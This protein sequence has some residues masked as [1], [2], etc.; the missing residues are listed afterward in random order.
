MA[1]IKLRRDTAANWSSANP[2]LA[3]GEPGYDTTNNKLKVGDGTTAWNSLDYLT[4]ESG[5]GTGEWSFNGDT[6]YNNE[7]NGLYI[8]PS[9]G[10]NDGSIY[11]PYEEE[12]GDLTISNNSGGSGAVTVSTN[13]KTW[14]FGS[15]G[16]LTL[17]VNV[18]GD[19]VLFSTAGNVELYSLNETAQVKIRAKGG[20]GDNAWIFNN[21]G[22]LTVPG[23][24][25]SETDND[26]SIQTESLPTEPPTTIVISGADFVAV[27]L[28]YTQS[29]GDP[30]VWTPANYNPSTDPYIQY[31]NGYGIWVPGF[32]QPL[33]VNTGTLNV[34]LAQWNT[35]PP[36][37]SVAPTGVYT[38]PNTYTKNWSFDTDGNFNIPQ[39]GDI[40]RYDGESYVSVL[41]GGGGV[42]GLSGTT[43]TPTNEGDTKYQLTINND[44][45]LKTYL[46]APDGPNNLGP[47]FS[48][49]D[50][51]GNEHR[52]GVV[53]IGNDD[54][55]YNSKRGGVYIGAEAGWNDNEGPQGEFAVA[56]GAFAA[57]NFA[58]DN[59]ITLNAT[60]EHLD[61][62]RSGL[63]IKPIAEGSASKVLN[64]DTDSGEVTY[65]DPADLVSDKEVKVIVGN[66]NYFA[67]VNRTNADG[68]TGID[69]TAV[70]Y[71]SFGN[72]ITLHVS[73]VDLGGEIGNI[74]RLIVSKFSPYGA[75]IWQ[76]QIDQ[77]VDVDTVHDVAIDSNDNIIVALSADNGSAD[78][79]IVLVKM[80]SDGT[81]LWQKDY[82]GILPVFVRDG[83]LT[84]NNNT[85]G[86]GSH[87]GDDTVQT[88]TVDGDYRRFP[89]GSV[90]EES[91][92]GVTRTPIGTVLH[93]MYNSELNKTIFFFPNST[94]GTLDYPTKY[95]T[96]SGNIPNSH[97]EVGAIVVNGDNIFV[98]GYYNDDTNAGE[99]S[100]YVMKASSTDGTFAWAYAIDSGSGF[101]RLFGMD[102]GADGH[103]VLLGNGQGPGPNGAV[104]VK[105]N[106]VTGSIIWTSV[107]FDS[108]NLA[109]DYNSGDVVV[110]N[111]NNVYVSVNTSQNIVHEN[112][113][114]T[115]VT[116]SYVSKINSNGARQWTRRI[117]PGPCA[118]IATGIDCDDSGGVYLSALTVAQK[119][120][121]RDN[122]NYFTS[123]SKNVLAVAKYSPSGTVM[124][125]RYIECDS[126][127]FDAS[128]DENA[129]PGFYNPTLNR[130][131]NLS[132]GPDSKLAVQVS[133]RKKDA[134]DNAWDSTYTES[135][136]FQIN[137]DGRE[138][139]VG[140][141]SEKFT[142]KES[143]IPGKLITPQYTLIDMEE[144][145]YPTITDV[146]S[147]IA[148][149]T[150]TL[151][152]SEG[153]LAQQVARS[154]PYN[155][156]FGNDG[157]LT[158]PNDGDLK[159]VQTQIGWFSIYG[160]IKNDYNNVDIRASV[161]D[162]S[163]GSVYAVGESDDSG[164]GFLTRYSSKG[165][166]LWS[167]RFNDEVDGNN[168]RANA[169]KIHPT[170]GN[171][172]VLLEYYGSYDVSMIV[173]VD[174][175]TVKVVNSFGLRDQGD[176]GDVTA[177][178]FA[179][180]TLGDAVI[181]GR[182]YDEYRQQS[183]TPITGSTTDL[184][185]FNATDIQGDAVTNSFY[186]SGTGITGRYNVVQVNRHT[187]LT[188]STRQGSGAIFDVVIGGV[189]PYTYDSVTATM[190][191]TNYRV[192]HKIQILGTDLEGLSPANDLTITVTGIDGD[193][194]IT[195][196]TVSGTYGNAQA[197]P[198]TYT[199]KTGTNVDV[200][201]GA[202]FTVNKN[203]SS[204]TN[205]ADGSWNVTTAGSNYVEG[206]VITVPGTQLYGTTPANDLTITVTSVSTGGV[207]AVNLSGTAQTAKINVWLNEVG[208]DFST[209]GTWKLENNLGGE[210]F[211]WMSGFSKVLSA[212]SSNDTE[213]YYSVALDADNNI[214]AAGEMIARNGAAGGDLNSYWCAVVT[215]I[216]NDGTH[217]W[218][219][220]LND[221]LDDCYAKCV[222]VNGTTVV[223]SHQNSTGHTTITK[224]DTS[225]NVKWQRRTNSNDDSSVALDNNGNIYAVV[226][227]NFENKFD[228]VIKVIRFNSVG[229]I[230]WRK[231]IGHLTYENNAASMR[232]KNGRNLTLSANH[233][234][235]SGYTYAQEDYYRNGVVIKIPATGDTDGFYGNWAVLQENYDVDKVNSTEA[236][237][238]TP[239]IGQGNFEPWNPDFSTQWWDPSDDNYYHTLWEIFDRD[240]G[241]IEFAD[242]TRQT[243]SAQMIP[244]KRIDNGM[245]H[246]LTL[247]DMGGHIYITNTYNGTTVHVPYHQDNPL[248]IGYTVVIV[249]N[250][251]DTVNIDADGGGIPIIVPGTGSGQYWDLQNQGMATLLKVDNDTWFMTGNVTDDN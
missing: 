160:P 141:G 227:A 19:S 121:N 64:Y 24:I 77:D 92:D 212:G 102:Q 106:S 149:T 122:N 201:S 131:R 242:G 82:H 13:N 63:F 104:V 23:G 57:R 108:E 152:F 218:T 222:A 162:P 192:G 194:G 103:L 73:E 249:N 40:R 43:Y 195:S 147:Q 199:G 111:L 173:E 170:R 230:I 189:G 5:G 164:Q 243:R 93:T 58:E 68:Q 171:V 69:A 175:D 169:V 145:S 244:Q 18:A 11:L 211:V 179:F 127:W 221:T 126:Y 181:V 107:F 88:I 41:G 45:R 55:G 165:E 174:P 119:N 203:S 233:L 136:T 84:I 51:I 39:G 132:L 204:T 61:P 96:I 78:D 34:P 217:A 67:I 86:T 6:A 167:I 229:E 184:L 133:V 208:V 125:Q 44:I 3:L 213:R 38:Y 191:G 197:A 52:S 234:H 15:D 237:T 112:G 36:L 153:E 250:S 205:Y 14:T 74:D 238:F 75:T 46:E 117:G 151:T 209:P 72:I 148:A 130:G 144:S 146:S 128:A 42:T 32:E 110:D 4:D 89:A 185:V 138:M 21:D 248:P 193:G 8:Q 161:V 220:A 49:G 247:D 178:D 95:Y 135:I 60:G 109:V 200:G 166:I 1:K 48:L 66:T 81:V 31:D 232:F 79:T 25:K 140:S 180:T 224:L 168:N 62:T 235:I 172:M 20:D 99:D 16:Q 115:S 2:V 118:S 210:A 85:P 190:A 177:Y 246:R 231:F 47:G 101:T 33:Y 54:V 139:T 225:G 7:G 245:N 97:L 94:L 228:D 156:V 10:T 29:I 137:Q 241:A 56:I 240:G 226:E 116:I 159:L 150:A 87:N 198:Y 22:D 30:N 239:V 65:S 124:W 219:K 196:A 50:S 9:Q 215:R 207:T 17:P 134:D 155:Y 12:G 100:G 163:D 214:Y 206:D 76:K 35:N 27:N 223:V 90:L 123:D 186:V 187:G 236:A 202:V 158:I 216:N 98:A 28:T 114:N 182:K 142:V 59:S 154:A 129:P 53:A 113:S 176:S 188:G 183:I 26:L 251:G 83:D 70:A 157:T 91:T 143:R 80:G 71:D 105:L 37:G 120:P